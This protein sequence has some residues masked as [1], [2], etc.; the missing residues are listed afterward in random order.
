MIEE[1]SHHLADTIAIQLVTDLE[2]EKKEAPTTTTFVAGVFKGKNICCGCI[3][4]SIL[5]VAEL[6]GVIVAMLRR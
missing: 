3:K 5:V 4:G 2:G 6:R 1:V